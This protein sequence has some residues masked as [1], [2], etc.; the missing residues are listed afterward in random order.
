MPYWRSMTPASNERRGDESGQRLDRRYV[1]ADAALL[2][3]TARARYLFH[4]AWFS[5]RL[6]PSDAVV[7]ILS[8]IGSVKKT[9][10]G[11]LGHCP[12]HE[13]S[14][15]SLSISQGMDGRV[16]LKCFAGCETDAVIAALGMRTT[17]LF[18]APN[19]PARSNGKAEPIIYNYLDAD[20]TLQYQV[21]RY[22]PK[23]FRQRRPDGDGGWIWKMTGVKRLPYRL[24][25]LKGQS[26][27]LIVEGEKDANALWA[28]GFA[29]TT[30][31]GGAGKWGA[32]E[33]K[34]LAA[35]GVQRVVILPDNDNPGQKHAELVAAKMKT[36]G[37]AASVIALPNLSPHGDVSD[38]F[39]AQHTADEL[40]ATIL[41]TPYVLPKSS[42]AAHYDAPPVSSE[43]EP[44]Y[45]EHYDVGASDAFRD[46]FGRLVCY[47]HQHGS[48]L[49]W[50]G[51]HWQP[52]AAEAIH[53][54]A[55]QHVRCWQEE[56]VARHGSKRQ[57][58]ILFTVKLEQRR[59][60]ENFLHIAQRDP[61]M[62]TDGT[63]WD[64]DPWLLGCPN[65]VIDLRTGEL[66]DGQQTDMITQQVGVPF[67]AAAECPRW[68]LFLE[69]VFD[70][71][72]SV[73]DYVHRALG[74]GLTGDLREQC[75]FLAVGSGSNG[76]SVFLDTL[77]SVFGTYGH[78][79]PMRVFVSGADDEK[80]H[81]ADFQGRRLILAA[82]T[83]P[84][85]RMNEHVLKN[86][87]G[88]ET[89]RV[90]RKYGH[91][92]T[93][94]PQAKIWLGVNHE[95]RV[96]DDS[97]GFWRRVRKI[98]FPRTFSGSADDRMLAQT[99]RA[100]AAGILAWMV[101]GCEK[102]QDLGLVAPPSVVL[103]TDTYQQAEDPL[104]EF[105]EQRIVVEWDALT[106]FA[107]AFHA[108]SEWQKALGCQKHDLISA[109]TFAANLKKRGFERVK[110]NG[111]PFYR[112]FTI[113]K[114]SDEMF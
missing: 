40:R 76:K 48:W 16:L 30:N 14:K 102:W 64:L 38:W 78:R 5:E 63:R 28:R 41:A 46:R 37:I 82:E 104:A 85:G 66:H 97:Y 31:C 9:G 67:D 51:H 11:W 73:I 13:D 88:G 36:V 24:P 74:Y 56:A 98:Q 17:A 23:E 86:L 68:E 112:G 107:R 58:E 54:L 79:A 34:A 25:E 59:A 61:S 39:T 95:P 50:Q 110:H 3:S 33:S 108:V 114:L 92:Y 21:C 75:F 55:R 99:L 94:K 7:H 105:F 70:G 71:D 65:G 90:E 19:A 8:K 43:S 12:A 4:L 52:D 103:A 32:A 106:S 72:A 2:V 1:S 89:L 45:H 87:T 35:A 100:E 69:E 27:V 80:F 6:M 84:G 60:I 15:K 26:L 62:S 111:S 91:P 109:K 96:V 81:F 42:E 57:A 44:D 47:D 53:W 93:I 113:L 29:A 22:P 101:R 49:I 83:K 77:E 10:E 20:G 18:D